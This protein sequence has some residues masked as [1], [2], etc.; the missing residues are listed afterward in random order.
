MWMNLLLA[1]SIPEVSVGD[2][3]AEVSA[4]AEADTDTGVES[5]ADTVADLDFAAY[6]RALWS[7]ISPAVTAPQGVNLT[8]YAD[9]LMDR[10]AN[11]AI[12][13]RTWQIAMDGSQKLPQRLLGT[14]RDNLDAGRPVKGLCT[15]IAAWMRYVRGTDEAGQPID[16]RDPMAGRL[17]TLAQSQDDPARI[18][19]SLL[20]VEDI[21]PADLASRLQKPVSQAAAVIWQDCVRAAIKASVR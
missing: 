1:C 9:C 15:A 19:A 21:F 17:R 3:A 18:V 5:I 6:V 16:V 2:G 14:V 4:G 20:S 8:E 11:P 12:R 13:H 10:Y 7:E